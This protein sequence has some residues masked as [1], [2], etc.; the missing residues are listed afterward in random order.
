MGDL[1][2]VMKIIKDLDET[3]RLYLLKKTLEAV[4][5]LFKQK[6]YHGDLKLENLL[7]DSVMSMVVCDFGTSQKYENFCD[8]LKV[9]TEKYSA[10]EIRLTDT[11]KQ[12]PLN[13]EKLDMYSLGVIFK[14]ILRKPKANVQNETLENFKEKNKYLDE[15][16]RIINSMTEENASKRIS[17]INLENQIN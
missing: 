12:R 8:E 13:P 7:I 3:N 16:N 5:Y 17:F 6:I 11:R 14:M 10:P 9:Y 2:N 1:F 4:A 15:L